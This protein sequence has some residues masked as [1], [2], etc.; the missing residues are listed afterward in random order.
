MSKRRVIR[1]IPISSGIALGHARVVLP[2]YLD[3]AERQIPGSKVKAEIEALERAVNDTA[4]ELQELRDSA[5]RKIGDTISKV[6]DAELLIATDHAFLA[7]VKK[8]IETYRRNA[9][10][11]YNLAVKR[12]SHQLS[13]TQDPYLRRTAQEIEAVGDRVLSHLAGF[14]E[15]STTRFGD[16]NIVVVKSLSPGDILN[17]RERKAIGFLATEGGTHSHMALIARSLMLPMVVSPT[18]LNRITDGCPLIIDGA[19]GQIIMNPTS[20]EWSDYQKKRRH[21]G[22]AIISR[23]KKLTEL[24]P[25]TSD[26]KPVPIAA[27]LEFPGPADDIL[28]SQKIPVGL[29]RTEFMYL[30]HAK[31]PDEIAQFKYYDRIAERF[32]Q[33]H[34]TF[35]TFDIGSDKVRDDRVLPKEANPALGWRGIRSMLEL[36]DVFKT[37][38][39]AILRASTRR[40]TSI[41]LPMISD[42]SELKKARKLIAQSMLELRR[43][44]EMFDDRIKIGVMVEVPSAALMAGQLAQHADFI[45]IGTNDLTQY[46]MAA[47]R[48]N[49]RVANLYNSYHPSVLQLIDMTVKACRKYKRPVCI[50]GEMAGE[51]LALALFVGM[52]IDTL[53]MN[54]NKVFDLCRLVKKIDS[55]M[56]RALVEP[57]LASKSAASVTRKLMNYKNAID[58]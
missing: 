17:Y 41:L 26:G 43:D 3:V 20:E 6:F 16:D 19:N 21:H 45:H 44:G 46:T 2:G 9:G 27:N 53:S 57:V 50:C 22:P 55:E 52:G 8:D 58:N 37:Q 10:Y 49:N 13:L 5:G 30:E 23:I 1:G 28:A 36:T 38:I 51:P 54:P 33:S 35:R 25:L 31:A 18:V 32:A 11:V 7:R 47:D 12:S 15:K 29:Y 24:P 42:L 48:A 14:G 40:N 56:A 39:K 34:V 4:A